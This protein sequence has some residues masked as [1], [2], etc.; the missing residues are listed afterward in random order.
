MGELPAGKGDGRLHRR[1]LVLVGAASVLWSLGGL[2]ARTIEA[3]DVWSV[4]FWR[5]ATAAA[6][7]IGF[8]LWRKGLAARHALARL[9]MPGLIVAACFGISSIAFIIALSL[10][11]VANV[12]LIFASAPLLAAALGRIVLGERVGLA[13]WLAMGVCLAG[14]ALMVSD[15]ARR[16]SIAGDALALVVTALMAVAIVTVRRHR[17]VEMAP[18]MGLAM[19]AC[20]LAALPL[21]TPLATTPRDL[22]VLALFGAGQL[23]VGLALFSYGAPLLPAAQVALLGLI[24]PVLAPAW[25]WLA[26][27]ERPADSALLGGGIVMLAL[28]LHTARDF[29]RRS[30]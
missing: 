21:A 17:D 1:G 4:V 5:S 20:M 18:A 6:F 25:V 2:L 27:G 30:D 23:G 19:L 29:W 15:S 26:Y 16:G 13:G 8:V 14:I 28:V 9:G 24:E 11:T 22:A 3:A 12:V 7:L 10:T